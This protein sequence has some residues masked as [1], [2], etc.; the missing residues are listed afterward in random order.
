MCKQIM[1]NRF[2]R[3][4]KVETINSVKMDELRLF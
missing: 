1:L 3:I 4:Y 2:T